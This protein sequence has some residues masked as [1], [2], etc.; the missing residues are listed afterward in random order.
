MKTRMH[1]VGSRLK[2]PLQQEEVIGKLMSSK[3]DDD[4]D[5]SSVRIE[6][7]DT[8]V[9][10]PK[11]EVK[12]KPPAE[13]EAATPLEDRFGRSLWVPTRVCY[14]PDTAITDCRFHGTEEKGWETCPYLEMSKSNRQITGR[15]L[16]ARNPIYGKPL[17]E[18]EAGLK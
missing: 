14:C 12:S 9:E 16:W 8:E 18:E 7:D 17:T 3:N 13:S 2:P 15:Q 4:V 11:S 5:M 10:T 6:V 1:P